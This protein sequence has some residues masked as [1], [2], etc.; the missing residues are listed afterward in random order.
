MSDYG[1]RDHWDE[2]HDAV[3]DTDHQSAIAANA[4]VGHM[5]ALVNATLNAR[6]AATSHGARR[7]VLLDV[8]AGHGVL[9]RALAGP[10]RL[11]IASDIAA[12][13]L[14]AAGRRHGDIGDRPTPRGLAA[15]VLHPALKPGSVDV[16]TCLRGLWT[17]PDPAAALAAMA[18]LLK[19]DGRLLVQLWAEAA[20]C[21]LI[22]TGAALLG[23][24]L[25]SLT[26]PAGV[27]SPFDITPAMLADMAAP[28]GLALDRVETG[29][30]AVRVTDAASYWREFDAVAETAAAARKQA[31]AAL[32][33]RIDAALP[34]VLGRVLSRDPTLPPDHDGWLAPI[35]WSLCVLAPIRTG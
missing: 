1:T 4:V 35:A 13:P 17:L 18:G 26:R 5:V 6:T 32:R 27:P 7:A 9:A 34:G 3:A 30:T 28:A 31:P 29:E 23:K 2:V 12:A 22:G 25:P 15:D 11:V 24:A 8:G 21:R 16:A 33:A 14:A 10:D 19:P 20:R